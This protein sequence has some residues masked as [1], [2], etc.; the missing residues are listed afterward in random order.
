MGIC[1]GKKSILSLPNRGPEAILVEP[2]S[3]AMGHC[4]H[5]VQS[6]TKYFVAKTCGCN[7]LVTARSGK[8]LMKIKV[9]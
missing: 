4:L 2:T 9:P 6:P 3:E 5:L 7:L 8:Y 1:S